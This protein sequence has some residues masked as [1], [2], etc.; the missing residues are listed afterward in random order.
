VFVV[1]V[2]AIAWLLARGA[3]VA[4]LLVGASMLIVTVFPPLGMKARRNRGCGPGCRPL[5]R[6]PLTE[7]LSGRGRH[8]RIQRLACGCRALN[9]RR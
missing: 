6:R 7:G 1:L 2:L 4:A 5:A 9:M 8:F 3:S